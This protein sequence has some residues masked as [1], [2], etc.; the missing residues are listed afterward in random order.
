MRN[1]VWISKL[2]QITIQNYTLHKGI[3]YFQKIKSGI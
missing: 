1:I 3:G 2:Q